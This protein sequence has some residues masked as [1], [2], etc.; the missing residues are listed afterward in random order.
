MP[1]I[2][3]LDASTKPAAVDFR[4]FF[5]RVRKPVFGGKLTAGQVSGMGRV[6]VYR[7]ER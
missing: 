4:V 1:A 7:K 6:L 5:N 3:F 2:Q